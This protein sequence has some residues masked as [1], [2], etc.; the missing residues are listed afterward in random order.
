M[1]NP[2]AKRSGTNH[3]WF[4]P[5]YHERGICTGLIRLMRQLTLQAPQIVLKIPEEFHHIWPLTFAL[6]SLMGCF[7]KIAETNNLCK[8]ILVRFHR[9]NRQVARSRLSTKA[10]RRNE[11]LGLPG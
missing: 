2:V 10:T 11:Y 9:N 1:D 6:S 3:A 5:I 4:R 8:Q 7:Q